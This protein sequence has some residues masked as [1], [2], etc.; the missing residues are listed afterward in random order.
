[1]PIVGTLVLPAGVGL[2]PTPYSGGESMEKLAYSPPILGA[3]NW[4]G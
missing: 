4:K 2:I 1:M 3:S